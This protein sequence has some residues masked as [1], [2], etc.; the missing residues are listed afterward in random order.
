MVKDLKEYPWSS[1]RVY[2]Y[3]KADGVTDRHENYDAMGEGKWG[4][5]ES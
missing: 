4:K 1:Y 3:G 5:A 2:A